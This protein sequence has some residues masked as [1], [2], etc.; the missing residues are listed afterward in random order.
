M[1]RRSGPP[2]F[3]PRGQQQ[4]LTSPGTLKSEIHYKVIL[5]G[6]QPRWSADLTCRSRLWNLWFTVNATLTS[7]WAICISEQQLRAHFLQWLTV[8]MEL[9]N[10]ALPWSELRCTKSISR[11]L[12]K[13]ILF[14]HLMVSRSRPMYWISISISFVLF[15]KPLNHSAPNKNLTFQSISRCYF[16]PLSISGALVRYWKSADIREREFINVLVFCLF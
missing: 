8:G 14:I 9:Q 12:Q 2:L 3:W 7:L 5:T 13:K 1:A 6:K 16:L 10:W 4:S 11:L 15:W